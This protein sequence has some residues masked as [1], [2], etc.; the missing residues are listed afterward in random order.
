[1]IS[2]LL[3]GIGYRFDIAHRKVMTVGTPHSIDIHG[4]VLH[5]A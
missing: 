1:M 4:A 2:L 3:V 5:V